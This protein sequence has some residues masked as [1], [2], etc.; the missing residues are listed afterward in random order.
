VSG[1]GNTMRSQGKQEEKNL[2][3]VSEARVVPSGIARI[4]ELQE[5]GW[6]YIRP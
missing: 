5:Q 6:A 1:C 4:A 3:L 2:S